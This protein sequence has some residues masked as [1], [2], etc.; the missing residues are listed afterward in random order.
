MKKEFDVHGMTCSSCALNVEKSVR[1]LEGIRD[2]NVSLLT[3]S[4]VV[5]TDTV[6]DD[7][8]ERAVHGAGYEAVSKTRGKGKK[9][10][11]K[12]MEASDESHMRFRLVV[13]FVFLIPLM[14]LAM[15]EMIGLP[16]PNVFKGAENAVL[17]AFTQFL[18]SLPIL[19]VNRK[20]YIGGFRG[21]WKRMPNMDSLVAIGSSAAFAYGIY[22]IYRMAYA[23]GHGDLAPVEHYMHSLYFESSAT[24]LALITLGKYL[25]ERSKKKTTEAIR[26]LIDLAPKTAIRVRDGKESIVP[27]EEIRVGDVL[28]VKPGTAVPV[29]GVVI[30][31]SAGIDQAAITGE[32]I[33]VEKSEGDS[34]VGSTLVK[35][36]SFLMRAEKVGED[37]AIS[38][39]IKLVQDA[40][41]TKAPIAKLADKIAGVFVPVV[42]TIALAAMGIWLVMGQSFEFALTIAISVLVISCPC[43]LGL[44]TPVAIMVGTGRGAGMGIFIKSA[45]ALEL[46]HS[47]DRVVLDKT[48]TI[49]EGKPEVTDII[50]LT[51]QSERD[52]LQIASSIEAPSEHPLA[53][54]IL[55]RA[56]KENVSFITGRNFT[57][58]PGRGIE[59]D[60]DGH[61]YFAGNIIYMKSLGYETQEPE[62]I[63]ERLAQE[64]KTNLYFANQSGVIGI[65]SVQDPVKQS[66]KDAIEAL[67]KMGVR[68][69]MLTGDNARTAE[70]IARPL[71]LDDTVAEAFPEDK[72]RI[73]RSY[74]DHGERVAMVGD[75]IND[76]PALARADVGIAIGAGTDIAMDAAD[77][78]LMKSDLMDV[79][80]AIE[81]S[82]ATMRNIK[83]NLF[84][85]FFY[86]VILI[87]VA[88]GV[89][90]HA[91][92]LT[93]NPMIASA[94]MS[95]SSIFV[96]TN[97][98]RLNTFRIHQRSEDGEDGEEENHQEN[99]E[100]VMTEKTIQVEGMSC[101]HCRKH[102]EEALNAI[103]GVA[104]EVNLE[105]KEARI[106]ICKPVSEE[107]L[108][109]AIEDAGYHFAGIR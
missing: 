75:G 30:E 89:F 39:I 34:V 83:E 79:V 65:I 18:L 109:Q 50:C 56:E 81:L 74:K 35:S 24:I 103:D 61:R 102:V 25:E 8:I 101:D 55:S 13:S 99:Q 63:A 6:S 48:G 44:A 90:Y 28:R 23:T 40:N 42:I 96:V 36:G 77:I 1:R 68:I 108:K 27:L 58:V 32:S 53:S 71:H 82:K 37:T 3:N 73:V 60:I 2:V 33:P 100:D 106:R 91:F 46:L 97:A 98:L 51:D 72:E 104:A 22:V 47:V 38:K 52:L 93:L 54:A 94:A 66:S 10:N 31:G 16:V 12:E 26:G 7:A 80:G 21:L 15:G 88:A 59:A 84:W 85:A 14:Y 69:T 11:V 17:Y 92:G 49:T 62:R 19:I 76:A 9:T 70:A 20:Y 78:V 64:G 29:D 4:M 105:K 57:N 45:E 5:D 67:H 86:N 107:A 95:L 41:A 43:A 87:P